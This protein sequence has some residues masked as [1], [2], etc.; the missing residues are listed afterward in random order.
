[1]NATPDSKTKTTVSRLKQITAQGGVPELPDNPAPYLVDW[2]FE[3]GPSSGDGAIGFPDLTAWQ[4]ITGVELTPWEART[5]RRLSVEY[6]HQQYQSRDPGC[7]APFSAKLQ[8]GRERV[9]KQFEAMA[10]SLAARK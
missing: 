1:M 4:D 5:L 6:L 2:L 8:A 10:K 7:P 9:S 3:I